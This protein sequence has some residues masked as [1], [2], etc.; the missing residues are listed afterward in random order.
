MMEGGG[1]IVDSLLKHCH[2]Y[3]TDPIL[4]TAK[5]GGEEEGG[6][7]RNSKYCG[8]PVSDGLGGYDDPLKK[9]K[10]PNKTQILLVTK[11][12]QTER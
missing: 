9:R 10:S 12:D 6:R 8:R 4:F 11:R 3:L 2:G 5:S 1:W 7:R